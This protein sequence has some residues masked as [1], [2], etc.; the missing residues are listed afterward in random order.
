MSLAYQFEESPLP[1]DDYRAH[2]RVVAADDVSR[3]VVEWEAT[4][5]VREAD[6]TGHFEGVINALIIDGHNSLAAFLQQ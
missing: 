1:L 2:V 5:D 4:F 3:C 6:R